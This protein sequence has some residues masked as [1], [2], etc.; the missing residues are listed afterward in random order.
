MDEISSDYQ[1]PFGKLTPYYRSV[2]YGAG[3]LL[4]GIIILAASESVVGA[5]LIL[6][7]IVVL[8]I[9]LIYFYIFLYRLWKFYNLC[10]G[11]RRIETAY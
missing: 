6:A 8:I 9:A 7:G 5:F 10:V 1:S 4:L 3:I 2:Y 11:L